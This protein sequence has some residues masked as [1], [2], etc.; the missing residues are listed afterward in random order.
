MTAREPLAPPAPFVHREHV[1]A[2]RKAIPP[3]ETLQGLSEIFKILGDP[4]RLKIC[5]ALA[6]HELCVSDI[7]GL[8]SL[9]ES[10]VSHQ[11]RMMKTLRLVAYRKEGKLTYYMLDDQH[12]EDLIRLGVRH[13]TE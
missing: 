10:A 4:T 3:E 12:V 8:L 7:A 13:V 11:L 9:S 6:R 2:A 1:S 5:L